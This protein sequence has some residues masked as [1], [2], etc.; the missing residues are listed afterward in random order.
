MKTLRNCPLPIANSLLLIVKPVANRT[1]ISSPL[2]NYL[3]H[4]ICQV[5][6]EKHFFTCYRVNKAQCLCMQSLSWDKSQN[7]YRQIV[8][9][10][11]KPFLLQF[12][13]RH[14]NHH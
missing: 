2:L 5:C 14:K 8:C 11:Y 9:I 13:H 10:W 7:N 1:H 4:I 12:C 3:Y 6:I